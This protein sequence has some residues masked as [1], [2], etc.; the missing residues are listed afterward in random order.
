MTI[1]P[2]LAID[3]TERDARRDG[4]QISPDTQRVKIA[5][6]TIGVLLI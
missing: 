3:L 1:T 6:S 4:I 2:P 5:I